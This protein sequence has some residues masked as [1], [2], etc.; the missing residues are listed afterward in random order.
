MFTRPATGAEP[1]PDNPP[2]TIKLGTA[3]YH[4]EPGCLSSVKAI[5]YYRRAYASSRE[6][7]SLEGPVSRVWYQD[8]EVLRRRAV[9]WRAKAGDA[10]RSFVAWHR[11][12]Y[13]WRLWLPR[14]WYNVGSC[15]TGYGGPPNWAHRNSSYEGAF[16]FAVSTWD[17]YKLEAPQRDGPYPGSAADAT[18]RQQL[19]VALVVYGHFGLSGWGCRG[20][21]G[22]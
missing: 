11:R 19:N 10:R 15:E 4:S 18:P 8:C 3:A 2:V 13:A 20:A 12:Q 21:W 14:G 17:R 6:Q 1:K 9:E 16:G 7:M 22:R 5:T